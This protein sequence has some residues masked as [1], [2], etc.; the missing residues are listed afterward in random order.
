MKPSGMSHEFTMSANSV[1]FTLAV[2]IPDYMNPL[3]AMSSPVG[4]YE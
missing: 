2:K 4:L 1:H 3:S